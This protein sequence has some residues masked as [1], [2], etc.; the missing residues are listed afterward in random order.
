MINVG[1]VGCGNISYVHAEAYKALKEVDVVACCDSNI[2]KGRAFAEQF[3]CQYVQEYKVL[4]EDSTIDAVS[5]CT[6]HHLHAEMILAA[7]DYGKHVLCEKPIALSVKEADR[8]LKRA[9]KSDS[10]LAICFQNRFNQTSLFLKEFI[11]KET[12]GSLKGV[13]SEVTWH[14]NEA[15]YTSG[16]WRSTWNESGG[17]LLIN[18][19]IHTIDLV[20][21]LIGTPKRVKGKVMTTFLEESIEVE[22]TAVAT[23]ELDNQ[24]PYIIYATNSY[25]SDFTWNTVFDFENGELILTPNHVLYKD[26]KVYTVPVKTFDEH[27]KEYWGKGHLSLIHSFVRYIAEGEYDP[28]RYLSTIEDGVEALKVV[29]GIYRSSESGK[30]IEL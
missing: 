12:L 28:E 22:D 5:I 16:K 18:Q 15:Y 24:V 2:Q 11:Q 9:A 30:W 19:V 29:N 21:W 13:R 4:L 27:E 14:R 26:E 6:P 23:A 25:S 3:N 20:C 10:K 1:I 8:V 17:G 7:M